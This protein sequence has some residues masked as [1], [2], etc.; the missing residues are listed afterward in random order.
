MIYAGDYFYH[1]YYMSPAKLQKARNIADSTWDEPFKSIQIKNKYKIIIMTT[2]GGEF[3][4]SQHLLNGIK[5]LGWEGRIIFNTTEGNEDEMLKFDP[6]IILFSI[7]IK[8]PMS[9]NIIDHR[10][11]KIGLY[12]WPINTNVTD[13]L[14]QNPLNLWYTD[15]Q[16]VFNERLEPQLK[17]KAF[18]QSADGVLVTAKEVGII[19]DIFDRMHR[20]FYGFRSVPTVSDNNLAFQKP[21]Y[22]SLIGYNDGFRKHWGFRSVITKLSEDKILRAYGQARAFWFLQNGYQG[23]IND[24]QDV[25]KTLNRNGIALIVHRN[26]HFANAISTNRII[27][28]AAANSLIIS[29][30]NPFVVENFADSVLY[31]DINTDKDA[32]YK[33]IMGHYE[34]A[35]ANPEQAKSLAN[36]AH[37]IFKNKFTSE[38]DLVRLVQL[39]E[40]I[41]LDEKALNL[42]YPYKQ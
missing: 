41:L 39:Y 16:Y 25:V 42:E 13:L 12:Y 3:A 9:Q 8:V 33:Q 31:F 29:D 34:W 32:M 24:V 18:L 36:R 20:K 19:K 21:N 40:K 6:D 28:A 26:E 7:G 38:R 14:M 17:L 5:N 2:N 11:K 10:S 23:Y 30:R 37:D 22:I 4:E 35:R 27:E 1:K 15:Q